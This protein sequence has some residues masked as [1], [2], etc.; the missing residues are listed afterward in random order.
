MFSLATKH[1]G[2]FCGKLTP[3]DGKVTL[4]GWHSFVHMSHQCT[5]DFRS[6]F[7]LNVQPIVWQ[8][9]ILKVKPCV[10]QQQISRVC[11]VSSSN[12]KTLQSDGLP[13][14]LQQTP[15]FL[16]VDSDYVL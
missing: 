6:S 8:V 5:A 9:K 15:E 16:Q 1:F 10:F 2:T 7:S 14:F 3:K 11:S 13:V 4:S 12:V